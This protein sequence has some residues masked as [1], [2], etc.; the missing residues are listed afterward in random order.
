PPPPDPEDITA[1]Y[2]HDEMITT[3]GAPEE[4][5]HRRAENP[6]DAP[7]RA[8]HMRGSVDLPPPAKLPAIGGPSRGAP[9]QASA[10]PTVRGASPQ[11]S[12][13]RTQPEPFPAFL[14]QPIEG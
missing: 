10:A 7:T 13:S 5:T 8:A 1:R 4:S 9:A 14:D 11:V 6:V 12:T 3:T 2:L